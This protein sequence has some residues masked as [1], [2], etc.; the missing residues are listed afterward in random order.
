MGKPEIH[1]KPSILIADVSDGGKS[2][3]TIFHS[4]FPAML[5]SLAAAATAAAATA[6]AAAIL[7]HHLTA[8]FAPSF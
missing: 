3:I 6:A 2:S 5:Q 7:T 1:E 8:P 4:R